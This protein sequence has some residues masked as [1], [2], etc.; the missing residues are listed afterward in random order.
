MFLA[1]TS[2]EDFW[3]NEYEINFLGKWCDIEN[4]YNIPTMKY[5]WNDQKKITH[6]LEKCDKYYEVFLEVL[7][8]ELNKI[9]QI[10]KSK[11]Y[12]RILLGSWLYYYIYINY[13]RFINIYLFYK[14]YGKFD[15]YVLNPEQYYTPFDFKDYM[16]IMVMDEFNLQ[17]YSKVLNFLFKNNTFKLKKLKKP[18]V[19]NSI[20]TFHKESLK[21][22]IL[23]KVT[24]ILSFFSNNKILITQPFFGD[25]YLSS[26]FKLLVK[27]KFKII[28]ND[29]ALVKEIKIDLNKEMTYSIENKSNHLFKRYIFENIL[30]DLPLIYT[31]NYKEFK[32]LTLKNMPYIPKIFYTSVS[33]VGNNE[34]KFFLSEYYDKIKIISHQHGGLY[35]MASKSLLAE[36]YERLITD[37]FLTAGWTEDEKTIPLGLPLL[38]K[39]IQDNIGKNITYVTTN[40]FKYLFRFHYYPIS[41]NYLDN[42]FNE[43]NEFFMKVDNDILNDNFVVRPYNSPISKNMVNNALKI[44]NNKNITI[45]SKNIMGNIIESS[46]LIIFDHFGTSMLETLHLNKATVIFIDFSIYKFRD[47]FS[48]MLQELCEVGILHDSA[49][50]AA[51]HINSIYKDID[52]WWYSEKVQNTRDSFVLKYAKCNNNWESDLAQ[53]FKSI[54]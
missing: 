28:F 26:M 5:L 44:V 29:M 3:N 47:E 41:T 10:N 30:K 45:D 19:H 13:D 21:K 27:N 15:T 23:R 1:T 20:K 38:S 8:H 42:F 54:S 24:E 17:V 6:A 43:M 49:V 11:H 53:F 34:V 2:L 33:L 48:L 16:K 4:K 46:R 36:R 37:Y 39:N 32:E 14:Q 31:S 18:L 22:R 7:T 51:Q 12:Y 25:N 40:S 50:S 35:G 9:H 52:K